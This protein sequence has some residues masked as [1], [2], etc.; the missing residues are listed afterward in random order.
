MTE[1][2]KVDASHLRMTLV[3]YKGYRA[4]RFNG[5]TIIIADARVITSNEVNNAFVIPYRIIGFK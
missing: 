5:K 3:T 1:L 2:Y 4:L